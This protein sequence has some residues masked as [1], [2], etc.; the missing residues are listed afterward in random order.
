MSAEKLIVDAEA[1]LTPYAVGAF[2]SDAV[3]VEA[4]VKREDLPAAVKALIDARW[5]YLVGDHRPRPSVA[6]D[7]Q[8][9]P[10]PARRRRNRP[11][12]PRTGSRRS[13]SSSSGAVDRDAARA[14]SPYSRRDASR[15]ICPIIPSATL[16]ERELQE[17]F[18]IMV[19]GT[20]ETERL[21][22]PDDW[23]D[24]VYPLRKAFK[25]LVRGPRRA[26]IEERDGHS[27]GTAQDS[28]WCPSGRST[29]PSR[30][31]AT[32]RS[33]W[34]A[35]SSRPRRCASATCT[36]ASR[37][38]SRA[39]TGRRRCTCSSGSAG[40]ARTSTPP[41]TPSASRQLAGVAGAAARA[42]HPRAG[43]RTR[44]RPQPPAVARRGG[45]RG[46]VRHAVHVLVARPRGRSW[47]CWRG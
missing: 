26:A 33:R 14:A 8:A 17:M 7:R 44:A 41:P 38:A 27:T 35:R 24:G 4:V 31:P 45:A 42:G 34:T 40:S 22:L 1:L 32:S 9:R 43:R 19:E 30:S 29:R 15:R 12:R 20:P 13:T 37:R 2:C 16:Y 25:G 10:K 6:E 47:T 36:A 3:G 39:R 28:S 46:R 21:L 11:A 5:G 23:P 18:G